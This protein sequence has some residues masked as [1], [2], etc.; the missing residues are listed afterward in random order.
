MLTTKLNDATDEARWQGVLDKNS[1]LDGSYFFAVKTTG[2]YCR[3][4]CSSRVPKRT[5]VIFYLT[6]EEARTAGFRACLRCAPDGV[7]KQQ[8]QTAA[9]LHACRLI[10]NSDERITLQVLAHQVGLSEHHFHRVFKDVTGVTPHD[11]YKSRQIAQIGQALQSTATVT[12]A[13]YAA[14]FNSSGRF[15]ENTNAML[16]MTPKAY[17]AGGQNEVIRMAVRTCSL[18][19]VLVAATTRG[20]CTIEF[21]DNQAALEK[22][23]NTR[24]PKALIISE[25]A[26]FKQWL[27][28]L[29]AHIELPKK[30][31]QLPLDIRGTVFQQQVWNALQAIPLGQTASYGD[32]ATRIGKPKAVRA[33]ATA[34][35][36]N[37][38]AIA[39]PC[40]RV[41]RGN[42]ELSGYRWGVERK[43]KI[44]NSETKLE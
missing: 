15:Y 27:T 12:E 31:L 17:K 24:F 13:M 42:G 33:V 19:L 37:V 5:N 29:L 4:S 6:T 14:G 3:P 34:C 1:S 8:Q 40:H 20:I 26:E 16:G 9:I 43:R 25:D 22:T 10:E 44:L 36:S 21:G 2:I 30:A 28:Q 7:T 38:L 11:Y 39:I 35:A 18:G 41:V 23:L 32:V